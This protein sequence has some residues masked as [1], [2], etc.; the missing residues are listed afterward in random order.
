M[1]AVAH[2]GNI[3]FFTVAQCMIEWGPMKEG[4]VVVI[5][6]FVARRVKIN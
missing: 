3:C 4:F 1:D 5:L 6:G 2:T